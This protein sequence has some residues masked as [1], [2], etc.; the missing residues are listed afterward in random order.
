MKTN[1]WGRAQDLLKTQG[2]SS[3]PVFSKQGGGSRA[4]P[5]MG[6]GKRGS[7]QKT[8]NIQKSVE[9]VREEQERTMR[10][11]RPGSLIYATSLCRL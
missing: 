3:C 5:E 10:N 6:A 8:P 2:E 1:K 4:K 7:Q 9:I 11:Q